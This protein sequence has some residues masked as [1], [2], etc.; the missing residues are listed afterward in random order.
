MEW[1][2]LE[3][4]G[5]A[6]F[7]SLKI[8]LAHSH[9]KEWPTSISR[10]TRFH[11]WRNLSIYQWLALPCSKL[12]LPSPYPALVAG[13]SRQQVL[14]GSTGALSAT[15]NC[16][17]VDI[18]LKTEFEEGINHDKSF[19][20]CFNCQCHPQKD[21]KKILRLFLGFFSLVFSSWLVVSCSALALGGWLSQ[22]AQGRNWASQRIHRLVKSILSDLNDEHFPFCVDPKVKESKVEHDIS[23]FRFFQNKFF[24]TL[25]ISPRP[26][27]SPNPSKPPWAA[28]WH[29]QRS[30]LQAP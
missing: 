14:A 5:K 11:M 29:W 23:S 6:I 4:F 19:Q 10:D 17:Q 13:I 21:Q 12:A 30:R 2:W 16:F 27:P 25:W 28:W 18:A 26:V 22:V 9:P 15:A 24:Q 8:V 20:F 3:Y 7:Y 1:T